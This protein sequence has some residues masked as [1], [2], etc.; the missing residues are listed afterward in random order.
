MPHVAVHAWMIYDGNGPVNSVNNA[1]RCL[2]DQNREVSDPF[3]EEVLL[4]QHSIGAEAYVLRVKREFQ[5]TQTAAMLIQSTAF[6][7][8]ATHVLE[9]M[10]YFGKHGLM[11]EASRMLD[12]IRDHPGTANEKTSAYTIVLGYLK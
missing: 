11:A 5:R 10:R 1:Y 8:P 4:S 3:F 2:I 7:L 12:R 6:L 9:P